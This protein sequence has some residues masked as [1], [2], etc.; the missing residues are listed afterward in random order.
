MLPRS[1]RLNLKKDFKWVAAGKKVESKYLKIFIR[2]GTNTFP[3]V[4]IATSTKIFTN[5]T[6]RNK[7]RRLSSFAFESI[8]HLLPSTINIVALPKIGILD[9]KSAD[10]LSD[11][12]E[13]LISEKILN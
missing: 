9:V 12:E 7:A 11:L 2:H 4:G 3:R 13:K 6:M 8:F 10:V 1:E 5:A